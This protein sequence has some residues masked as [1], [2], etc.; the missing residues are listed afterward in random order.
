VFKYN[1]LRTLLST[2]AVV[3]TATSGW[4]ASEPQQNPL[5]AVPVPFRGE[6]NSKLEDCG[7]G[8]NDSSLTIGARTIS[9][10][11]SSGPI[12]AVI[13]KGETSLALIARLKSG[14]DGSTV[15]DAPVKFELSQNQAVL[16][17]TTQAGK[18]F[19]RYKC[20]NRI[21]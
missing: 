5:Q 13:T 14:E 19:T 11:E 9:F 16:K 15:W 4:T 18:P 12:L 20:P 21:R 2:A 3:M 17:D 8:L 7:T 6:W 10:Y 1:L